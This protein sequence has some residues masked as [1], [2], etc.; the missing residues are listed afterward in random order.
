MQHTGLD[1]SAHERTIASN[2]IRHVIGS[3][4][5]PEREAARGQVHVAT[6][7]FIHIPDIVEQ[8]HEIN[9]IGSRQGRKGQRL[10]YVA[11]IGLHQYRYVEQI[12]SNAKMRAAGSTCPAIAGSPVTGH[13]RSTAALVGLDTL[14]QVKVQ[15]PLTPTISAP[16]IAAKLLR[17]C[18]CAAADMTCPR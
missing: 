1:V 3:H 9:A 6:P 8:A 5:S 15:W 14:E 2:D 10:E 11:N 16:V 4:G 18:F 17:C 7:D 13:A 12:R